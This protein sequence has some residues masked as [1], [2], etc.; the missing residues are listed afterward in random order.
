MMENLERL[1]EGSSDSVKFKTEK[2]EYAIHCEHNQVEDLTTTKVV[3]Q[4]DS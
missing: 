2:G 1:A 4:H 3:R